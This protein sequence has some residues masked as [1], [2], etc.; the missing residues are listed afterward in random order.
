VPWAVAPS[1]DSLFV[2]LSGFGYFAGEEVSACE[3]F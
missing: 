2:V 1:V 3:G